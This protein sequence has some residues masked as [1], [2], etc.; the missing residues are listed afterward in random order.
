MT[1]RHSI[2]PATCSALMLCALG[3][4]VAGGAGCD[5]SDPAAETIAE[6]SRTFDALHAGGVHADTIEAR[7]VAYTTAVSS[8]G[9]VG[10]GATPAQQSA[11]KSLLAQAWNGRAQLHI[12][13]ATDLERQLLNDVSVARGTLRLIESRLSL[14]AA[15][16]SY[17]PSG[18]IREVEQDLSNIARQLDEAARGLQAVDAEVARLRAAA[19]EQASLAGAIRQREGELRSS[20]AD[21]PVEQRPELARQA[22]ALQRE[23]DAFDTEAARLS[24]Q[25]AQVAPRGNEIQRDI[26]R[27]RRQTDLFAQA[28][29]V[30][31]D[32]AA[33]SRQEAGANRDSARQ[34]AEQLRGRVDEIS[35]RRS[36]E[37]APMY[38]E[39]SRAM[40]SAS[41][42]MRQAAQSAVDAESRAAA[43]AA[44]GRLQQAEAD[45]HAARASGAAS[46]VTLLRLATPALGESA[47]RDA[48][49]SAETE[50][51]EATAAAAAAREEASGTF[52]RAGVR[53]EAGEL[54]NRVAA[55]LAGEPDEAPAP[56]E[57]MDQNNEGDE[58]GAP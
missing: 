32:R 9:S 45:M 28:R 42:A 7:R 24:A 22:V 18:E 49:A 5:R 1:T 20:V 4:M 31:E 3:P 48:L 39:A 53:G 56:T 57:E 27:L 12:A 33:S 55:Q 6:V 30:A 47:V 23:A 15:L 44:L 54:L 51:Q 8:L 10:T 29:S 26:D 50:A 11:A 13:D 34:A 46:F 38:E 25:A 37:L 2:R 41:G 17:D 58:G 36:E 21:A 19:E 14:A 40:Q 52:E 43:Q 35:R 16:E